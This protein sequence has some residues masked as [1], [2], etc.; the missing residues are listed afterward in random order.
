MS[1]I[2]PR[3]FFK[4]LYVFFV[5]LAIFCVSMLALDS[6][7]LLNRFALKFFGYTMQGWFNAIPILFDIVG[8]V[9]TCKIAMKYRK[10]WIDA[11]WRKH[12]RN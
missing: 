12:W 2:T 4:V 8:F 3:Q 9:I 5:I 7:M 10:H 11:E 1:D 6:M